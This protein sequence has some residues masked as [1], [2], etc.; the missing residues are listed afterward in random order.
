[1]RYVYAEGLVYIKNMI[2]HNKLKIL[3]EEI[4]WQEEEKSNR[5]RKTYGISL[6]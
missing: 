5:F 6:I 1:M 4:T 3:E 2:K